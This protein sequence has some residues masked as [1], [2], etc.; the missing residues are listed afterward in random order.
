MKIIK[1]FIVSIIVFLSFSASLNAQYLERDS[2]FSTRFFWGGDIG[3]SFGSN[4]Y[5][6]VNPVIGYRLTNR[7]SAGVG[8][9]YTYARSEY[10]N[11]EGNMYGGNVFA[12][13]AIIKNLGEIL[14]IYDGGGILLYGE[15]SAIN[16]SNYYD[17]PG[18]V[19]KWVGTP[20]AGVAYQSPIGDKS[21]MLVLLLFNFNESSISPYPNPVFKL[22]FQF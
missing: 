1:V 2:T 6:A 15:Y 16:I 22:S 3:L 19:I 8:A 7:L 17:F 21:Y 14:P 10:Y 13:Y 5:I 4:T 20:L 18:T 11:Y 12:S 9:N